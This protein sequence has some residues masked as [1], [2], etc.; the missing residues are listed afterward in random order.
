MSLGYMLLVCVDPYTPYDP[1]YTPPVV[2]VMPE[3]GVI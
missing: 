2:D 1:P 3:V